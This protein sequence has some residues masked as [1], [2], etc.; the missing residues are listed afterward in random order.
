MPTSFIVKMALVQTG[1][2]SA[3]SSKPT[4]AALTP[5]SA[6]WVCTLRL[7]NSQNGKVPKINKNDG[8][9]IETMQIKAPS[10]PVGDSVMDAPRKETNVNKGPGTAW[11]KP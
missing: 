6:A 7:N 5:A 2:Y 11:V 3:D 10:Q 8:R 1:R 9:K 4:T